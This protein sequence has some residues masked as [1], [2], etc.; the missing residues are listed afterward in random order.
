MADEKG[1]TELPAL[2]VGFGCKQEEEAREP[3]PAPPPPT[4]HRR[5]LPGGRRHENSGQLAR[6]SLCHSKSGPDQAVAGILPWCGPAWPPR[7]G[8]I[9]PR[10]ARPDRHSDQAQCERRHEPRHGRAAAQARSS[11]DKLP[12]HDRSRCAR[13]FA[14]A[15]AKIVGSETD[16]DCEGPE[17][18]QSLAGRN[19][20][21]RSPLF[22]GPILE[23]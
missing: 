6:F 19:S 23:L 5:S 8:P 16:A 7:T 12:R 15:P 18:F 22:I 20:I 13:E 11:S 14:L 21:A 1:L 17:K 3:G 4:G 2:A 10:T 9:G